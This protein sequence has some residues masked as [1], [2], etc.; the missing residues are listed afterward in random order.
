[1]STILDA[2]KKVEGEGPKATPAE[3]NELDRQIVHGG[4]SSIARP[5]RRGAIF[6]LAVLVAGVAGAG[7][8]MLGLSTLQR[9]GGAEG[10]RPAVA[11]AGSE[12]QGEV[13]GLE[14]VEVA[15]EVEEVM[16]GERVQRRGYEAA[17]GGA[18]DPETI[19]AEPATALLARA[20]DPS[21]GRTPVVNATPPTDRET[22]VIPPPAGGQKKPD[23]VR[24]LA[25]VREAR[26]SQVTREEPAVKREAMPRGEGA[27]GKRTSTPAKKSSVVRAKKATA[28]STREEPPVEVAVVTSKPEPT[29]E[30]PI[31]RPPVEIVDI[32][33]KKP[34]ATSPPQRA[35]TPDSLPVIARD[36]IPKVGVTATTWHPYKSRRSA[37]VTLLEAGEAKRITVKQGDAVGPF[38]VSEITP[39]GVTLVHEG[40]E[41]QRRVGAEAR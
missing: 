36:S 10:D 34:S 19:E 4:S 25:A 23:V 41:L 32:A 31:Q 22:I 35:R 9:E 12:V 33:R 3:P 24:K 14:A 37:A 1:M 6:F 16:A 8:T 2:L 30:A 18:V 26:V 7:L 38:K 11:S 27:A 15:G 20:P 40:V 5:V 28:T 17:G 13:A 39:T 29:R 21:A